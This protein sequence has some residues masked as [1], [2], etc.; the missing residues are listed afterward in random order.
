[1]SASACIHTQAYTHTHIHKMLITP[2]LKNGGGGGMGTKA[3]SGSEPFN[4]RPVFRELSTELRTMEVFG[5][6]HPAELTHILQVGQ[7]TLTHK[8]NGQ[9]MEMKQ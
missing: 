1:M 9:A 6:A 5:K 8:A 4:Y 7:N 2:N 3:L